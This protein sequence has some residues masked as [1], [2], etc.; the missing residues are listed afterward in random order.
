[1]TDQRVREKFE[2]FITASPYEK[3]VR[4]YDSNG[5]WPFA[6]VDI[7]VHLAW[8]AWQAAWREGMLEAAGICDWLYNDYGMRLADSNECAAAIRARAK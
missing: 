1:M 4:R 6:Y 3:S 8:D 7:D 5:M 2:A